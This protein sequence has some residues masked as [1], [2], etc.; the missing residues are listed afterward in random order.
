MAATHQVA[1][2]YVNANIASHARTISFFGQDGLSVIEVWPDEDDRD[3]ESSSSNI[4]GKK[5]RRDAGEDDKEA[6]RAHIEALFAD[7]K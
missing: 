7:L 3:E 2:M 6:L 4:S 5:R 1:S